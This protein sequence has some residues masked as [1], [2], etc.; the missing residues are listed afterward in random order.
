M[1]FLES[2]KLFFFLNRPE[3]G[4]EI[5]EGDVA[6]VLFALETPEHGAHECRLGLVPL[7]LV[8]QE[9]GDRPAG[10]VGHVH[11]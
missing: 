1:E 7:E 6:L 11:Q 2:N 9:A 5:S 10:T 8:T 3:P 4:L